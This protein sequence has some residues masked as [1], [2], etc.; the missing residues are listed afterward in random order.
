MRSVNRGKKMLL[1]KAIAI[2]VGVCALIMILLC[3]GAAILINN[4][5]IRQE[6]IGIIVVAVQLISSFFGCMVAVLLAKE[7]RILVCI[8]SCIAYFALL[9]C[10]NILCIDGEFG[11]VGEGLVAVIAGGLIA[12]S[13][14][15]LSKDKPKMKKRRF[16]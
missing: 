12:Y 9:V 6:S 3:A 5:S 15:V 10:F 16:R 4:G 1:P 2:G 14:S 7:K 8:I 13:I 11:R